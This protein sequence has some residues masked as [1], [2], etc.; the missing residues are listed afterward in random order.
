MEVMIIGMMVVVGLP[1]VTVAGLLMVAAEADRMAEL[2]RYEGISKMDVLQPSYALAPAVE[3]ALTPQSGF[4]AEVGEETAGSEG[5][6]RHFEGP[7]EVE[8]RGMGASKLGGGL[9]HFQKQIRIV[10]ARFARTPQHVKRLRGFL[11]SS[12][13]TGKATDRD[14]IDRV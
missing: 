12:H 7:F 1:L 3:S 2:S 8:G 4:G 9:P 10:T 6:G 5:T 14:G 13:K 11:S